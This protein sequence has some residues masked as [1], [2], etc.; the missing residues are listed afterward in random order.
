MKRIPKPKHDSKQRKPK[1]RHEGRDIEN[2]A[3]NVRVVLSDVAVP[4]EGK[5]SARKSCCGGLPKLSCERV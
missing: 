1:R 3:Q 4:D 5:Q 2:T